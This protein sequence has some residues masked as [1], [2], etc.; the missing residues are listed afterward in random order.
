M[1]P[2]TEEF[3]ALVKDYLAADVEF[4]ALRA[5]TVA[6][7]TLESG[8]GRSSLATDFRNFARLKWRSE[9]NGFATPVDYAAHDGTDK[10]CRFTSRKKFIAGYWNFLDRSPYEGWRDHVGTPEDFI[11]FIG[12][13]YTPTH[14]YA[15]NVLALLPTARHQIDD[16][17]GGG[18]AVA[19]DVPQDNL[20]DHDL[21][22]HVVSDHAPHD[23]IHGTSEQPPKPSIKQFIQSPNHSSRNGMPIRRVIMHY[24]TSR[25]VD[26]T[27]SHFLNPAS[28]VS[29]HYV[30]GRDG[31]I[32][33]MVHD[34]DKAWHAKN[35]NADSIG[36]EHSAAQGDQM[37][38]PQENASI[39][40]VRWLLSEYKL[41]KSAIHGHKYTPE[42]AGTTDCPERLFGPDTEAALDKWVNDKI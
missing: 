26:G 13:I 19:S 28:K 32:F 5:V 41:P 40:L 7:W 35:A 21:S 9:M 12:P 14:L 2:Y 38:P 20:S 33:Q 22:D 8:Y 6:Q 17:G 31:S 15:D 1:A 24:T 10:Y 11:R 30:I 3:K 23:A 16:L 18:Q 4:A 27:I 42:N 29:A 37:T 36:I 25:N 39:A 34:G